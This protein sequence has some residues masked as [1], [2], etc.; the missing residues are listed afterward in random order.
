[1]SKLENYLKEKLEEEIEVYLEEYCVLV[2]EDYGMV[3]SDRDIEK[4]MEVTKEEFIDIINNIK[5]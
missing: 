5:F 3:Y 2:K 1:M 4:A